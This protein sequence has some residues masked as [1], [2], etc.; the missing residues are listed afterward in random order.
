ME[1]DNEDI[2]KVAIYCRVSTPEQTTEN[3][4]RCLTKFAKRMGW[5]YWVIEETMS[6][7]GT[8]PKKNALYQGLMKKNADA[9]LVYKL[10]RWARN[11]RELANDMHMLYERGVYF[12]SYTEHID[13]STSAGKLQAHILSAFAEF[14]RNIISERVKEGLAR[15]KENGK[16]PGRPKGSKD[17][18]YRKKSGYHQR[19][20]VKQTPLILNDFDD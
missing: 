10:D 15:A 3:Q 14:E 16:V 7:T 12:I 20:A 4:V 8:R 5:D 2:K 9:V 17:K 18:N 11:V 19:W 13:L 6:S 1:Y